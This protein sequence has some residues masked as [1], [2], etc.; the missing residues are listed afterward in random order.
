MAL[1]LWG[2]TCDIDTATRTRTCNLVSVALTRASSDTTCGGAPRVNSCRLSSGLEQCVQAIIIIVII[3][4]SSIVH[5]H[6]NNT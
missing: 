1:S 5:Q 4:S 6:N 3:I 2:Y